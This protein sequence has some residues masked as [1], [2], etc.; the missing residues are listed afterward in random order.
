MRSPPWT[1]TTNG[2]ETPR[3][4]IQRRTEDIGEG[5]VPVEELI[6]VGQALDLVPGQV[7]RTVGVPEVAGDAAGVAAGGHA[8]HDQRQHVGAV[9]DLA[10]R[11]QQVRAQPADRHDVR[12]G[13]LRRLEPL[14][15]PVGAAVVDVDDLPGFS[16][17][18][19]RH[20]GH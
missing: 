18:A 19:L 13:G 20:R 14:I 4:A 10:Q 17:S 8:Q 12:V 6:L 16:A 9:R 7:V 1:E 5:E 3:L 15:R 11:H 2:T